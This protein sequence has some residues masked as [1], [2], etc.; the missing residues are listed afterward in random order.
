MLVAGPNLTVDRTLRLEALRP[1]EVLRAEDVTVSPGGKGLNVARTARA[2]GRPAELVGFVPGR[3]GAAA[4]GMIADEG[5]GLRAV[6][7]DGEIRSAAVI[8]EHDGRTTVVNEPGP[9]LSASA[10]ERYE[11]EVE[12]ALAVG[13]GALV[14]SGS[15]PPGTPEDAYG[16]LVSLARAHDTLSVVDAAGEWLGGGVGAAADVVAPNLAE[17]EALLHGGRGE[18]VD[19]GADARRRAVTAAA[20]LHAQ[21]VSTAVVTAADAGVA[22]ADATGRWWVPS[23]D[24]AA[25]NAVGAGDAFVAALTLALVDEQPL[26]T[27]LRQAVATAAASVETAVGGMVDADRARRLQPH[28]ASPQPA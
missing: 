20:A 7:C 21:G 22:V 17:A 12:A 16:R 8:L 6:P 10:W 1:G 28:V 13:V 19:A 4:A 18:P 2:L 11:G 27:A 3:T 25:R 23:V 26:A 5:V 24:V 9:R 14:C 15:C